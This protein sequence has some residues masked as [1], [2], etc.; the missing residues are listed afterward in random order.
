MLSKRK[1]IISAFLIFAFIFVGFYFVTG[2]NSKRRN[3]ECG[4]IGDLYINTDTTKK[5]KDG[6]ALFQQCSACHILFKNFTGPDL[7][8]FTK[9]G[10]W[11]DRKQ[12]LGYLNDPQ[13]F[14]KENRIKYVEDLY[15]SSPVAHQVFFWNEKEIDD[16]VY[17]LES[18]EKY[19]K[20]KNP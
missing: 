5:Y 10:P 15:N 13:K 4:A 19:G 11:G 6:K 9:R 7:I 1:S 8:G 12:I 3:I 17:Y 18:E 16:L 2:F 14:H 20:K